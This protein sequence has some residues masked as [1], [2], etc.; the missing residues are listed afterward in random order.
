M[1]PYSV[2]LEYEVLFLLPIKDGAEALINTLN[3]FKNLNFPFSYALLVSDNNSKEDLGSI[4]ENYNFPI[5][6]SKTDRDL[7]RIGNW[8]N[9]VSLA[10]K[11]KFKYAK[12]VFAGDVLLEKGVIE[13]VNS[14]QFFVTSPHVVVNEDLSTYIMNHMCD[15]KLAVLPSSEALENALKSGNWFAGCMSCV[16]MKK[17]VLNHLYF[18]ENYSWASDFKA[19]V[20]LAKIYD[21]TYTPELVCE[22]HK[23]Y[24]KHYAK[25][26]SDKKSKQEELEIEKDI[27]N[28]L[29][30]MR[31]GNVT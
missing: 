27:K 4:F 24:R 10:K 2:D 23:R 3:S 16:L 26:G 15:E 8:N 14:N 13:Q 21:V 19:W 9:I 1:I 6:Y 30:L 28:F 25:L 22:F 31:E 20:N 29:Y 11:L 7:S 12:F 5:I 17:S 18:D